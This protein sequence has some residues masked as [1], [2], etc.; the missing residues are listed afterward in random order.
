[1]SALAHQERVLRAR[2]AQHLD[3]IAH[4]SQRVAQ[5]VGQHGQELV[6]APAGFFQILL[7]LLAI[8]NVD[9]SR[10]RAARLARLVQKR[11]GV[12]DDDA[13]RAVGKGHGHLVVAHR[14]ARGGR[15]LDRQFRGRNLETVLHETKGRRALARRRGH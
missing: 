13:F 10:D 5:F 6:L 15:P 4:G 7:H 11:H 14:L 8:G 9:E 1:M 12:A 3:G 2:D